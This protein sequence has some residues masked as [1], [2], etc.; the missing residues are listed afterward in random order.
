V[1]ETLR[2]HKHL[3]A[4]AAE[5]V[6][7]VRDKD[8]KYN[9]SWKQR[10]G[11]G[12]Y[13]TIVRPLDRMIN[14]LDPTRKPGDQREAPMAE[15][16]NTPVPAYDIFAGVAAE[17]LEG[18]DGSL[19]ACIRDLRRYLLLVEAHMTEELDA[20]DDLSIYPNVSRALGGMDF[21]EVEK[22]VM[23][24]VNS[25]TE[26]DSAED[27]YLKA[28]KELGITRQEAKVR[29]LKALY[30]G[31]SWPDAYSAG[32]AKFAAGGPVEPLRNL[33]DEVAV[34]LTNTPRVGE[35][36]EQTLARTVEGRAELARRR[37]EPE[38][39]GPLSW[40][41]SERRVPRYPDEPV[42]LP[43]RAEPSG[44][45]PWIASWIVVSSLGPRIAEAWHRGGTDTMTLEPRLTTEL[46]SIL[47][48]EV[49]QCYSSIVPDEQDG[50]QAYWLHVWDAPA[51]ERER[52]RTLPAE[53]NHA[54][55]QGAMEY[56]ELYEWQEGPGK[57]ILRPE[58]MGWKGQ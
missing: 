5:D 21:A 7:Y 42:T 56:A 46:W 52:W 45:W 25:K 44:T 10:G 17:G 31:G 1:S 57:Y 28:A 40:N 15:W 58:W 3:E 23:E 53:L 37:D 11:V 41:Q 18:P 30:G 9:A 16:R 29:I 32:E 24:W 33:G 47:P 2:Y 54:E 13:F 35:S 51:D 4:I 36:E 27:I 50:A 6:R 39:K 55:W 19:I 22:R 43:E 8:A 26:G 48:P 38:A 34:I 12:A 20:P 14:M 49:R